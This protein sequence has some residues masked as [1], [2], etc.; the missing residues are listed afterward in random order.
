MGCDCG[1][2]TGSLFEAVLACGWVTGSLSGT[3]AV[4]VAYQYSVM[5]FGSV[6]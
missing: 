1:F 5:G 6:G 3:E 4:M 2:E